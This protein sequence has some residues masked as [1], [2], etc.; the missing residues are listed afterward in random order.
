MVTGRLDKALV[1][2]ER[3]LELDPYNLRS[4]SFYAQVLYQARRFDEA[5][6]MARKVLSVPPRSGVALTALSNSLYMKGMYDELVDMS[7]EERIKDPA[8]RE[9]LKRGYAENGYDWAQKRLNDILEAGYGK[10]GGVPAIVLVHFCARTKDK[11]RVIHWLEKAYQQHDSNVPY[12]R[13]DPEFDFVRDDPRFRDIMR[14][15]GLPN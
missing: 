15:V 8:L 3:A 14:R 1:R 9:D 2:S 12:L 5:I 11:D 4:Q 6:A 13:I 7:I 10:P